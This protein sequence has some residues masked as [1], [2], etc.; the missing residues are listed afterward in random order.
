[1][2]KFFQRHFWVDQAYLHLEP[3]NDSINILV[4]REIKWSEEENIWSHLSSKLKILFYLETCPRNVQTTQFLERKKVS[5]S[6][7][8]DFRVTCK[9]QVKW[10]KLQDVEKDDQNTKKLFVPKAN[11]GTR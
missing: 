10:T 9:G 11:T 8:C 1:M 5:N 4:K 7:I 3:L 2:I 6:H